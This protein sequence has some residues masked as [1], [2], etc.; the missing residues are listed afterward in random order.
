MP[1]LGLELLVQSGIT[2]IDYQD[3]FKPLD[4]PL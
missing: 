2:I 3:P 1:N 4:T